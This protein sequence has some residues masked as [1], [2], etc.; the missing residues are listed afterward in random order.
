MVC[1]VVPSNIK[2]G[3]AFIVTL[4]K[5]VFDYFML[6]LLVLVLNQMNL[7]SCLVVTIITLIGHTFM[8]RALMKFVYPRRSKGDTTLI[9]DKLSRSI[10][11]PLILI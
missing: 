6:T 5:L 1:L 11:Y 3:S 2:L 10:L 9:T 7:L 8:L 4:V